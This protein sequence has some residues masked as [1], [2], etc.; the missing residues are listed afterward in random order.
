VTIPTGTHTVLVTVNA[1]CLVVLDGGRCGMS[2][3]SPTITG[4]TAG[5]DGHAYL[6]AFGGGNTAGNFM[7]GSETTVLSLVGGTYQITALYA[8]NGNEKPKSESATFP[9]SSI[10]VQVY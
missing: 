3:S 9:Q 5:G 7:S 10:I 1:E 4:F 6:A 8:S 2:W